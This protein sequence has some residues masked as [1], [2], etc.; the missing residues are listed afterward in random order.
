V[1]AIRASKGFVVFCS[2]SA[3]ES[4]HVLREIAVAARFKKPILPVVLGGGR[5]PDAFLYYLSAH[6]SV[7]I[8]ADPAWRVRFLEA[9][10]GLAQG[11]SRKN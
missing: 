3:Y 6:Q 10:E 7:D 1:A 4:D 5:G 9:L 8:A 2:P 11:R